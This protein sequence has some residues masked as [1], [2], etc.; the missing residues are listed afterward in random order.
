MHINQG[1]MFQPTFWVTPSDTGY[2]SY[3]REFWNTLLKAQGNPNA[4]I[5]K[6]TAYN[7]NYIT[8]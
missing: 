6:V 2:R 1:H 5:S 8:L 4:H 3:L 7:I